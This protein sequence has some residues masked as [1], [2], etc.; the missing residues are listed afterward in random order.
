VVTGVVQNTQCYVASAVPVEYLNTTATTQVSGDQ[1]QASTT[2]TYSSDIAVTVRAR[3]MGYLPF[4][5]TGTISSSGI[6]VT[7]VWLQDPNFKFVVSGVNITFNNADPDT[8]VR[9]SGDFGTDGWIPV[10]SQVTV[11]GSTN[12][13]GT[14]ELAGVSG[15]TLTLEASET[16]TAEGPSSGVTL[17]FTRREPTW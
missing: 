16:L 7:A 2:L 17:T 3:E 4:Q 11:E 8:I 9:A 15:V 14:Y 6:S 5:T 13:D 12:N 1:Y 10:M